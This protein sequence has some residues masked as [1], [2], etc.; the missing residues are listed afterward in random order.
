MAGNTD[1]AIRFEGLRDFTRALKNVGD[2]LE[3]L[4]ATHKDAAEI[5][6]MR[7]A[8]IAPRRSGLLAD[9]LRS[10][11]TQAGGRVKAGSA[12]LVPYAGPIH[13]GWPARSIRP[14]PFIYD[15]M[16]DRRQE[17]L[18]VYEQRLNSIIRTRGL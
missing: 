14:Q 3:E 17:V 8:V 13:F 6:A 12:S 4:K 9:S 7:A 11:G 15:A 1:H 18:D 10:T 2:D 16:D 5:V